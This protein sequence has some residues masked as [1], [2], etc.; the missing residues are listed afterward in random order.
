M[1]ISKLQQLM[2]EMGILGAAVIAARSDNVSDVVD[3]LRERIPG[4]AANTYRAAAQ[5][6][7]MSGRLAAEM[8]TAP[9]GFAPAIDD[10]PQ[11]PGQESGYRY[12]AIASLPE[13]QPGL[14]PSIYVI[15]DREKPLSASELRI[16]LEQRWFDIMAHDSVAGEERA[17]DLVGEVDFYFVSVSRR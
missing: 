17:D 2:G 3:W 16:A 12:A 11:F 15:V 10:I 1:A 9:A 5:R 14:Q 13:D 4:Y 8:A 7:W 6:L